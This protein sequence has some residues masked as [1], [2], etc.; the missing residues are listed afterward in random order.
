MKPKQLCYLVTWGLFGNFHS[1]SANW[2]QRSFF[3]MIYY[4][5]TNIFLP[6]DR[7][8]VYYYNK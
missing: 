5:E 3:I 2:K 4:Y 8:N 7:V 1:K 6:T